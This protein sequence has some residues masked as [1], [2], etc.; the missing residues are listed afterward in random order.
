MLYR[1]HQIRPKWK[2]FGIHSAEGFTLP[3]RKQDEAFGAHSKRLQL[4]I[5]AQDVS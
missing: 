5:P 1:H 3:S 4:P 2:Q